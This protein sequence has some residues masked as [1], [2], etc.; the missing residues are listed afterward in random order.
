[1]ESEMILAVDFDGAL[2]RR[3]FHALGFVC[4]EVVFARMDEAEGFFGTV[5]EEDAMADNLALEVDVGLGDRG[6]VIKRRWDGRHKAKVEQ[7]RDDATFVKAAGILGHLFLIVIVIVILIL[8]LIRLSKSKI[9][10]TIT[11]EKEGR[12]QARLTKAGIILGFKIRWLINRNWGS[13]VFA[14]LKSGTG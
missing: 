3:D 4:A 13:K 2:A 1:M 12:W 14:R 8:I 7:S 10:I 11:I 9:M 6:D 5:V